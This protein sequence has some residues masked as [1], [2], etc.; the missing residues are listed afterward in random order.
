LIKIGVIDY[1]VGNVGSVINMLRHVGA[2]NVD[3]LTSPEQVAD[4]DKLILPGV[5]AYD[6]GMKQLIDTGFDRTIKSISQTQIDILGICLGMQLL[7]EGSEEGKYPGLG[8]I[9]GKITKFTPE[10]TS[11][12]SIPHMGWNKIEKISA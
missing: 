2:E 4:V 7:T 6:R 3:I 5:G 10:F 1:G 8:L 11:G 9:P 12:H